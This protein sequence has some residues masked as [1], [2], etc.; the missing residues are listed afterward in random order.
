MP[1]ETYTA[2]SSAATGHAL[3]NMSQTFSPLL[4][5]SSWRLRFQKAK[6]STKVRHLRWD[7]ETIDAAIPSLSSD[8]SKDNTQILVSSQ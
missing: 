3:S 6:A 5:N 8:P 2:H 1:V 4:D 7:R